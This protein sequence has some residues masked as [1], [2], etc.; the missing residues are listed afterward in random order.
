MA[1]KST[2]LEVLVQKLR[3]LRPPSIHTLISTLEHAESFREFAAIVREFLP[4]REKEILHGSSPGE[5][6]MFFARYFEERYFPLSYYFATGEAEEYDELTRYIPAEF[7]G[8]SYDDYQSILWDG[9]L[10]YQILSFLIEDEPGYRGDFAGDILD[11][12]PE[13]IRNQLPALDYQDLREIF[14]TAGPYPGIAWWLRIRN[15]DT[16]NVFHDICDEDYWQMNVP[17]FEWERGEVEELTRQWQRAEVIQNVV[18][19]AAEWFEE[20]PVER[21][22]E[23]VNFIKGRLAELNGGENVTEERA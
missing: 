10:G 20:K 18:H 1:Q 9:R 4:E 13:D 2:P 6:M 22:L 17:V 7:P 14:Q 5:Q 8:L 16:G 12:I 15:C 11:E 21:F 23:V 3:Q 19:E